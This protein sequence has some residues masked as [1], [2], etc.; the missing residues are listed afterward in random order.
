MILEDPP[1]I[2]HRSD[3]ITILPPL[4]RRFDT[5]TTFAFL[6][7]EGDKVLE[8]VKW[9]AVILFSTCFIQPLVSGH[10]A[11]FSSVNLLAWLRHGLE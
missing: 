7:L 8:D 6:P 9:L 2:L 11:G 1:R 3:R 4:P 5:E 10:S